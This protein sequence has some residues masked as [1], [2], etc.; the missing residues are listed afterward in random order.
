MKCI[1]FSA[2]LLIGMIAGAVAG[3]LLAPQSGEE[4]REKIMDYAEDA[5]G[6]VAENGRQLLE[7]SK[8]MLEKGKS[9]VA[10]AIKSAG[11]SV[12]DVADTLADDMS[13][14]AKSK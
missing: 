13:H 10:G 8:D 6:K 7:S 2:G 3:M 5:T 9:Q 11:T 12:K 1:D 14:L 4:T